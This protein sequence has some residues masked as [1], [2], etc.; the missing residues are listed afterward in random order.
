MR[1]PATLALVTALLWALVAPA[2]AQERPLISVRAGADGKLAYIPDASGNRVIDFSH[3]GYGGGGEPIP[4][5]PTKITVAPS[6]SASPT[7]APDDRARIQAALDAV[8]SM[9]LGPDGFRGA[10]LLKPGRYEIH[11]T[12]RLNGS[13]VVLR[14]SGQGEHENDPAATVLVSARP[15]RR[16]LIEISGGGERTDVAATRQTIADTFVPIGATRLT[17]ADATAFP[18]GSRVAVRRPSNAAWIAH[19]GMGTFS[20][21]RPE[22]RVSWAPGSRDLV[23]ERTI[24]AVDPATHTLTLDAPLTASLD[25]AFGGGTIARCEFPGRIDHVGVENLRC[26]SDYDRAFPNARDEEHAWVC[27]ALDK[28]EHA[29]VRQLTAQHF[30]SSVIHAQTDSRSLTIEDCTALAPISELAAYRRRVFSISGQ[31]TLV[32]RCTSEHGL[33]DFTTGFAAT[34]PNVF[35]HCRAT[36]A[37]GASGPVESWASGVLYDNVIIRGHGLHLANRGAH[38]QGAGWTTANSLLWNCE[39][40]DLQIQS[41]PGAPNQAYGSKGVIVDDNLTYDPRTTPFREFVRGSATKPDSLYLAQLAERRGPDAPARLA[42]ATISISPL[43]PISL[44]DDLPPSPSLPA[45]PLRLAGAQFLIGDQRAFTATTNWSWYLGQMPR[46]LARPF[47]PALTRFAPGETGR[48]ATDD[49][50]EVV[51]ALPPG[52]AFVHHYGLW[53]D[54]RRI[55]HNFYGSPELRA[56]DVT[57]PF[58]EMPWARS[59]L[60]TDWNGLSQYDLTKF[61]PWY[62]ARVKEFA[63]LADTHGRILYHNFYFQHALQ[64]TRAHYVDFPWRPVNCLQATDLPDENPA[65]NA[66]YDIAHPV[67]RDLH[68]RYIRHCLDVLRDNTNV[69]YALDREYSGPLAFVQF[70]LDTIAEWQ[71]DTG[72][73]VFLSLEVPKAQLDILLADPERRPLIAAIDFHYWSYRADGSLFAIEGGLNLAP[74]EQLTRA[75]ALPDQPRTSGPMQRYRALREYRDAFPDLVIAHKP[76]DFPTLTAAVD[77]HIPAAARATTRPAPLVRTHLGSTWCMAAPGQSYLLYSLAGSPLTL[78]L[79]ADPATYT[80]TWLDSSSPTTAPPATSAITGGKIL[81]LT[82]PAPASPPATRPV[83]AWLTR[84]Q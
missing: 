12:L 46:P 65:A 10:V 45:P 2:P 55:H 62:F 68:R 64:E 19:L 40:T 77:K 63:D 1:R 70:W 69:I 80:V 6:A 84:R 78:D 71:R 21:W 3:A 60:G 37:L 61:N 81:T 33:R 66:F 58:M 56:D 73:K 4:L 44:S 83:V 76:D 26:I 5:V 38:G 23:W 74:R 36:A 29:W 50:L 28:V 51:T 82:P 25:K 20:G 67:R 32:Q 24:T 59:G 8:A 22:N 48:G 42:R 39:A 49:L 41:P 75:A 13:G 16:T 31:L 30:V 7:S 57:P 18:V 9:P 35:L 34:G 47:G 43:P 15:S 54:R 79:T 14:G 17:A 72:K 53:Y 52:G 11:G 27:V